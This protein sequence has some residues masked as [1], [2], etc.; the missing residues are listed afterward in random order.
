MHDNAGGWELIAVQIGAQER[1]V[2]V[3][4]GA[5][6]NM[7]DAAVIVDETGDPIGFQSLADIP[8]ATRGHFYV[9]AI[10]VQREADRNMVMVGPMRRAF[11][12]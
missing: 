6:F 2:A 8:L 1:Q 12:Q 10:R 11:A 5:S 4:R 9:A 3:S 7:L